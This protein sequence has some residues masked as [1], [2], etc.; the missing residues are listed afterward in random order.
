MTSAAPI[1]VSVVTGFLGAGKTSLLNRLLREPEL[2]DTLVIINEWGEIGL[3]H[4]LIERVDGDVILLSSGCLCCSLRGDLVDALHDLAARRDAGRIAPFNRIV[5]ETSGI[6]DPAPVLRA[7]MADPEL[8]LRYRLAGVVTLVDAVN[9]AATLQNIGESMRQ[10]ALADRLAVTKSDLL[11]AADRPDRLKALTKSLRALNPV[12]PILDIAAGEFRAADL[13]ALDPFEGVSDLASGREQPPVDP[14][15]TAQSADTFG[16]NAPGAGRHSPSIGAYSLRLPDPIGAAA[17]ALFLDLLCATL[18]P[19]LLRVKGL[20]ALAEHP[21]EPLVIHGVQ[22]IFHPPRRLKGWPDEDRATRIV[23]VVDG[24]ERST[25]D[26]LWAALSGAPRIDAPDM[27]A[28]ANSP[29]TPP[30]GGLL[31]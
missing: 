21:A 29:L 14:H 24:L 28:L 26:K 16:V 18:G 30:R 10:V 2:A 23:V 5:I 4:L 27:A 17:F 31:A 8:A 13:I 11:A 25:V 9:G 6:A 22:H 19:R 15:A 20:V 7:I 1:P 12:A 3:D